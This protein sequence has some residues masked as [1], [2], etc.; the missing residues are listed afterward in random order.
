M[1]LQQIWTFQSS[2]YHLYLKIWRAWQVYV[3]RQKVKKA[4]ASV[5][6]MQGNSISLPLWEVIDRSRGG[7]TT[8]RDLWLSTRL[9]KD[10]IEMLTLKD[11][12]KRQ[13]EGFI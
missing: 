1:L 11:T 10:V 6:F 9:T 12:I 13:N 3:V 7:K 5:A 4:K 8:N 2:R